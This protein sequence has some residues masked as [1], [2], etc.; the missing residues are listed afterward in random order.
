MRK[1]LILLIIASQPLFSQGGSNYSLFGI[2][3]VQH[4]I[5]AYYDA[6]GGTAIAMPSEHAINLKNPAAWSKV[7]N[8]RLAV[9]YKFNQHFL[10]ENDASV[11]QNNG[12][13][14]QI[15]AIMA[16]DSARGIAASF[17]FYPYSKVNYSILREVEVTVDDF[18]ATGYSSYKG[19][20]GVSTVYLGAG[21]RVLDKL[22]LGAQILLNF[23]LDAFSDETALYGDF[24][25]SFNQTDNYRS[26]LGY[27]FGA[28]Y[29]PFENFAVGAFYQTNESVQTES[30]VLY[31]SEILPDTTFEYER[32]LDLP[33][34]Y[35][36]GAS[37]RTKNI[38]VGFDLSFQDFSGF[39]SQKTDRAEY[40][41]SSQ[42]S[43]GLSLL[44]S[45]RLGADYFKKIA[46]NFGFGYKNLYYSAKVSP[47]AAPTDINEIYGSAGLSAPIEGSA[48][49]DLSLTFGKRGTQDNGLIEEYFGRLSVGLSIGDVWFKPYRRGF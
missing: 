9:G 22:A 6:M 14:N 19:F 39:V 36:F 18:T 45:D 24:F 25:S 33:D 32:S 46:Y 29:E 47:N 8:T 1:L 7:Q 31:Y 26:G 28:Y 42:F 16:I 34:S 43:A 44:P 11:F 20:G 23:G 38:L 2:G 21:G 30:A 40:K 48:I 49:I 35:G 12:Q 10:Y 5:G 15:A 37:Y 27:R 17:G 3:D 13:V 4:N 41:N